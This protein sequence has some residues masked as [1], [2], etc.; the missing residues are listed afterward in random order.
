[1]GVRLALAAAALAAALAAAALAPAGGASAADPECDP[2]VERALAAN[3][4]AGARDDFRAVRHE[5]AGIRDPESIF[6]LS[7]VSDMFDY[8]H[9]NILF[10]PGR[11]MSEIVGFLRDLF[12]DRARRTF[13]AYVGRGLDARVFAGDLPW[14]P[15]LD[16]VTEGGNVLD[17]ARGAARAGGSAAPPPPRR[18]SP[19]RPPAAERRDAAPPA[20]RGELF[21]SLIGGGQ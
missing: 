18:P 20:S 16:I 9:S 6:D 7:C 5:T 2:E 19:S 15:G 3:A 1:M 21:R 12:C 8:A 14:L 4:E 10:D 17:D 11:A 13:Q